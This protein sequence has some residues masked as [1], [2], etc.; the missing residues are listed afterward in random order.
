MQT[1][2]YPRP[3][4]MD[5]LSVHLAPDLRPVSGHMIDE[6]VRSCLSE[7]RVV[8]VAACSKSEDASVA[9]DFATFISHPDRRDGFHRTFCHPQSSSQPTPFLSRLGSV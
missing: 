3:T 6:V 5:L 1:S 9:D 7:R 2:S 4:R 8:R